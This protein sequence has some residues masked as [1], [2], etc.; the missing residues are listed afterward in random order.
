MKTSKQAHYYGLEP[1]AIESDFERFFFPFCVDP[2]RDK[3]DSN[4][5]SPAPN[6][7]KAEVISLQ[8]DYVLKFQ[9]VTITADHT[10]GLSHFTTITASSVE[11][12]ALAIK[13]G[14]L[15]LIQILP[16]NR[17]TNALW[18]P[19]GLEP[20]KSANKMRLVRGL[21]P[22]NLELL[23]DPGANQQSHSDA[24]PRGS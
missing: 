15:K 17:Q 3:T 6:E 11:G 13:V 1:R 23:A 22:Q 7:P 4:G 10:G 14:K 20:E 19:T 24:E 18:R 16:R 2:K 12:R 8:D 5:L 9:F 21:S